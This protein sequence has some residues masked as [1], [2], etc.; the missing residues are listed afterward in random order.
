MEEALGSCKDPSEHRIW[1]CDFSNAENVGVSLAN[2]IAETG[3]RVFSFI[4]CA[5]LLKI[6]PHRSIDT[7]LFREVLEVNLVSANE[8]ILVLMK[9]KINENCLRSIVF[10]SSI[11]SQFGARGF[12]AY[13]ASKGAIDALM[14]ALAVEFAPNVRA[15]SIL[16]GGIRTSMTEK[17]FDDSEMVEKFNKDYPLGIGE[18]NDIVNMVEYLISDKAKWI[19]G[20]QLI[21]D[22]G[23]TANIT[24]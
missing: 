14:K 17:I 11:A 1:R 23:R 16:P 7:K 4:N 20:Q 18:P 12:S 19:T 2:F 13:C 5:A 8:I 21:V 22:G 15:N 9:K 24:A 3:I 6:L 10:I